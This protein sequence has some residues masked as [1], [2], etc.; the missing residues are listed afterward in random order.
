MQKVFDYIRKHHMIEANERVIVGVS[1]GADSLCLLFVL[2][3]LAAQM[4]FELTAVHVEHG[5]RGRESLEDALYTQEICRREKIDFRC[6]SVPVPDIAARDRTGIEEAARKARYEA[7]EQ[8]RRETGAHKTA[9][10]HNKND[11]AETMLFRMARGSG[12][13][14]AGGILPVRGHIIRP[15]L[16]CTR[17][18]IEAYLT[19]RKIRWRTDSTNNLT[20]Y[21]RNCLRL[22]I[23]PELTENVN[24]KC[25]EHLAALGEEFRQIED[26]MS[27]QAQKLAGETAVCTEGSVRI[28]AEKLKAQESIMQEYVIRYALRMAGCGLKDIGRGHI[29]AVRELACGQSGRQVILPDGWRAWREFDTLHIAKNSLSGT[30]KNCAAKACVRPQIPGE[31]VIGEERYIFSLFAYSGQ[32]IPQKIYTKWFD[33][34]KI[35]SDVILRTRKEGDFLVVNSQGGTKKLKSYFIDEKIPQSEREKI[36]L[37]AKDKEIIWVTGRRISEAYKVTPGTK[38]ILEVRRIEKRNGGEDQCIDS[39]GKSKQTDRRA[40]GADQQGL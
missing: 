16:D 9:V 26:Y 37:L 24:A 12:L 32:N 22:K 5:I 19:E 7:F 40:C 15:L 6:V 1:G 14:G 38:I 33:Y 25:V 3:E 17:E 29:G 8:I 30:E 31:A 20:E 11:Q 35:G 13:K 34:D 39:G 36:V 21:T 23:L 2:K 28:C 18:E 10:A 4:P 27:A